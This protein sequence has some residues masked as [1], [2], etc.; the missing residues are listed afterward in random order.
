MVKKEKI[1]QIVKNIHL[2][3]IVRINIVIILSFAV[4]HCFKF[5]QKW[6]E[7][8]NQTIKVDM[9]ALGYTS[10]SSYCNFRINVNAGSLH[11]GNEIIDSKSIVEVYSSPYYKVQH[12]LDK[13]FLDKLFPDVSAK[14]RDTI[15]NMY[16]FYL[17][18]YDSH[19]TI[20]IRDNI[21]MS[22]FENGSSNSF[23][24]ID[25]PKWSKDS[26][27][28]SFS[29]SGF[30]AFPDFTSKPDS[31]GHGCG[32]MDFSVNTI[33]G[34]NS[35]KNPWDITQANYNIQLN[36]KDISCDTISIEFYGATL[37]SNMYPVPD[38]TTMSG[39]EFVQ[40]EKIQDII[41]NGLRFHTEFLELKEI[42]AMRVFLLTALLSLLIAFVVN[43]ITKHL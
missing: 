41:R 11:L 27:G 12:N 8:P 14:Y 3:T 2:K 30:L 22:D 37:F 4:L 10:D 31:I 20:N 6:N 15:A 16:T 40:P 28:S 38:K 23:S 42:A 36:C 5:Y 24:Y 7:I 21:T 25:A 33:N 39:I 19:T 35:I 9:T 18:D 17:L 26:I 1:L 13:D 32:S 29:G 34:M 43:L